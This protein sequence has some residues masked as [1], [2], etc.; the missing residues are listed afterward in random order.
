MFAQRDAIIRLLRD[1]DLPTVQLVKNQLATHGRE[2]VADLLDL[3][4]RDDAKDAKVAG[5]VREILARIDAREAQAELAELCREFPDHGELDALE[6]AA[7]LLARAVSPSP[8]Q[9]DVEAARLQLDQWGEALLARA[10][11]AKTVS[12][13]VRLL[14][15][16][17]GTELGF[18]GNAENFYS[19][20]NSLLPEVIKLRV[21]IPITL[22]LVYLFT[23]ARAGIALE[24]VSFPGHFLIR[25]DEVI[26]DPFDRGKVLTLAECS[27][28]LARQNLPVDPAY[29]EASPAR[30]IF[31]RMLANLLYLYQ[32]E[33][34]RLAAMLEGWI[35][36]LESSR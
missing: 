24:G 13:R 3:L 4:A 1:D 9:T 34:K 36:D 10:A 20:R 32:S 28:L 22:A 2:A 33:D 15:D 21:G 7:V 6:Y 14:A 11:D 31:R 23:A 16:F 17:F 25:H 19:V 27:T 26:L 5:H 18:H 35:D 30:T 12:E 8:E 29:F